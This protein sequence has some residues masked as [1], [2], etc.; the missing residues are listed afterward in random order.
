MFVYKEG[1]ARFSTVPYNLDPNDKANKYI[2]LTNYSINK[3]NMKNI[4]N[5]NAD[6]I[7]GGCKV[8]LSTIKKKVEA[9]WNVNWDEQIWTEIKECCLKAMVSAQNDMQFNP[10]CFE[11]YGFD[12]I[13]D[14]DFKLWLLEINSS[15][16]LARDTRLDDMIKQ[17]LIDDTISLLDVVD[18]D[19]KR[20]FEVLERRVHEDFNKS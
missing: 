9:E 15:P 10:S 14:T 3:H 8:S 7:E 2:H 17:K 1:F 13:I 19:R 6:E 4:E 11:V 20:L 12:V 5:E 18:F 16:S